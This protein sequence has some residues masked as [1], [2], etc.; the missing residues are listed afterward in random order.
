MPVP[1]A[2]GELVAPLA[3]AEI[4]SPIMAVKNG[5]GLAL[6]W[7]NNPFSQWPGKSEGGAPPELVPADWTL[8][9]V[10]LRRRFS[11]G[12]FTSCHSRRK[13]T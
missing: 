8:P 6:P 13:A 9:Q 12:Q 2:A 3:M 4:I 1:A 5:F 7:K 11:Q 10:L